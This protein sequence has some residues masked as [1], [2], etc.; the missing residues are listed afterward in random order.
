MFAALPIERDLLG[1]KDL[2]PGF[3]YWIESVGGYAAFGL[4][5]WF[6]VGLSV[7]KRKDRERIP[8]WLSTIVVGGTCVS[9]ICYG[10]FC[11]TLMLYPSPRPIDV[12]IEGHVTVHQYFDWRDAFGIIGGACAIIAVCAPVARNVVALSPRRILALA[13]LSFKEAVRRRV[14]YVFSILLVVFLFASWFL[15][16]EKPENQV[17]DYVGAVDVVMSFLLLLT[18]F[19]LASFSIP[20]DIKQQTIHT[21]LTKPVQRFEIVL[22]RFLGYAALMTMV[23]FVMT[24]VSLIYLVRQI[25]PDAASESLKARDPAWG[26]LHFEGTGDDNK[27]IN[28]GREW[29]YRS[30]IAAQQPGQPRHT[31]IWQFQSVS[32]SF[33]D[34]PAVPCEFSFDV[35]RSTKGYEDRGISTGLYFRTWRCKKGNVEEYQKELQKRRMDPKGATDS[36]IL[37][38]LSE[39]YGYFEVPAV[40][41]A[42]GHTYSVDIPGGLFKNIAEGPDD[43][44]RQEAAQTKRALPALEVRVLCHSPTQYVG[45]AKY[46]LWLRQ[47]DP[48]GRYDK[49][50]FAYN[51]FKAQVVSLWL[52]LLLVIGISVSLSTFLSG[53]ITL[54]VSLILYMCG[55]IGNFVL[56]VA[57]GV[58]L[59]GGVFTSMYTLF[60]LKQPTTEVEKTSTT[61]VLLFS[62][63]WVQFALR[64]V[65][66][67]FPDVDRFDFTNFIKE[68]FNIPGNQMVINF[69]LL[70]AY[71]VPWLV[72]AYY[73]IKWREV[74]SAS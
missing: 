25:D 65:V 41:V 60:Q 18:A 71:V 8:S 20:N 23:L 12:D 21:V 1:Y 43:D 58:N 16:S 70:A 38:D 54:L 50:W 66:D 74:A 53:V 47:D 19:L 55:K 15:S 34:R 46:D 64:R 56:S 52:K 44:M 33:K 40:A 17:R 11:I 29:G 49:V 7:M 28:V 67:L 30:Y 45:M 9:V 42:T 4:V 27:G 13:R 5:L 39:K 32:S 36:D 73:L 59:G 62:D 3:L 2:L 24:G 37:N 72:L 22:G 51:F 63:R 31:A 10:I 35:F 48:N 68:G 6:I 61:G 69:L 14:L 26:D 57:W